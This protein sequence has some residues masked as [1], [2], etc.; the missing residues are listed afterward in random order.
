MSVNDMT[1]NQA[2]QILTDALN[3]GQG[4]VV[5]STPLNTAEFVTVAQI[6]LAVGY[7]NTQYFH[8]LFRKHT[9][10]TPIEY[11]ERRK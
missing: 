5:A 3:Q 11:R 7:E 6:A 1:V 8:R 9:G 10:M 2:A 4:S